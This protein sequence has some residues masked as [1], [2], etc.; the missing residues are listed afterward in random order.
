MRS[1]ANQVESVINDAEGDDGILLTMLAALSDGQRRRLVKMIT[2]N[3][4]A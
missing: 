4:L 1:S 2:G 3:S